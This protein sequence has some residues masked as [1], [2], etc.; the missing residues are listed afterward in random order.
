MSHH[1]SSMQFNEEDHLHNLRLN[2]C[3]FEM[4]S[5]VEYVMII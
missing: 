3:I 2:L 4:I 5:S 1:I